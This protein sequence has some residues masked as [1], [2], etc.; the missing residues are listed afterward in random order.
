MTPSAH[1]DPFAREHLPPPDLWPDLLLPDGSAF[2]YP[3][4]LNCAAVLLDTH[5]AEGR[6]GR[7]LLHTDD[8]AW[9]YRD[10]Q[11]RADRIAHVLTREMGL[12]PGN[13][14]L[15][16]GPNTPLFA[17]AWLGIV[18]AGGIVVATMPLLRAPELTA[19]IEKA[20]VTHALVDTSVTPELDLA[21][22]R[23]DRLQHVLTFGGSD[24]V[25]GDLEARMAA[26]DDAFEAID[27]AADDVVLVAFTSGT[28]GAAKA[29]AHFHRDV[30]AICDAFPRACLDVSPSDVFTGSPPLA[31]TFGLGGILLFPMRIGASAAFPTRPGVDGLLGAIARHGCTVC[32]TSP[33]AYRAMLPTLDAHDV[34]SLR[35][36][37]SAGEALPAATS[38]AWHAATGLR[39][40]D[41]IGSTE[42]LH[43]FISAPAGE[44]RPGATGRPVAGYEARVVDASGAEVAPGTVGLLAVRGPTGCRYLDDEDRQRRY[45]KDGWNYPGDTYLVD[46]DG[47][48]HYQART[49]DLIVS[50]GY[51][52]AGLEIEEVLLRHPAVA[53]CGVVGVPDRL[54]GQIVKAF[55][56]LREGH[57]PSDDLVAALQ[58]FVKAEIAPYKYPRAVAFLDAL[59][60]TATGKLQRFRLREEG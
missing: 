33:T 27:T 57:A 12:V 34:S 17:A 21:R 36:C 4:R 7:P 49:D 47:F 3:E 18:K 6:G 58:N 48:F 24:G 29:T 1:T 23:T 37:I 31:F 52:I 13:R 56:V 53:E 44:Q 41:G 51:N 43:I 54:R 38:E 35:V 60:R 40:I 2:E 8:G 9:S 20:Q 46:T 22:E 26:H 11:D 42:M 32:A 19:I 5:V 14:V 55:V 59:P 15:L 16:H 10:V 45:V 39:L 50:G 28:T 25:S 30:L